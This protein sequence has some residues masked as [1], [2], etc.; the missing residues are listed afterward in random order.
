MNEDQL[1]SQKEFLAIKKERIEKKEKIL[2]AKERKLRIR[3]LIELGSLVEKAHIGQLQS[4]ALLGAFAEIQLKSKDP[5]TLS[6]WTETGKI[7][8][9]QQ[10]SISKT[11]LIVSFETPPPEEILKQLRGY[12]F[13]WNRFRKEWY[14]YGDKEELASIFEK[15]SPKITVPS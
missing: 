10:S 1:K 15:F 2:K 11:P 6:K 3:K 5:E 14:G 9:N 7:F 12:K 13:K 4:E 8:L